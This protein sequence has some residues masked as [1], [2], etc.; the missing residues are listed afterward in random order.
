MACYP[1][2][3][4]SSGE[5]SHPINQLKNELYENIYFL[6]ILHNT[7]HSLWEFI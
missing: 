7:I 3:W 2:K 5:G 1:L 6:H 4:A